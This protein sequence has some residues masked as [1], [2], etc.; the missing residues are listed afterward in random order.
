MTVKEVLE[1]IYERGH[2]TA[3]AGYVSEDDKNHAVDQALSQIQELVDNLDKEIIFGIEVVSLA[4][5]K[6]I[7]ED[8]ND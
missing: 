1:E 2:K 4:N 6:A 7:M 5:L 8:R 3:V